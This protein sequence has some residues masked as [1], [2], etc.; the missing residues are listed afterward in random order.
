V[1]RTDR[2]VDVER[3]FLER[4]GFYEREERTSGY[5]ITPEDIANRP[6][7]R[8]QD[9]FRAIPGIEPGRITGTPGSD[10]FVT[11]EC[12]EPSAR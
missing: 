8:P 9:L 10:N 6:P 12:A 5:F 2:V 7:S 1:Q 11:L 3:R 4:Q